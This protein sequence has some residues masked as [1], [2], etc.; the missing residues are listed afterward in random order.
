VFDATAAVNLTTT[1][2]TE[3]SNSATA[4]ATSATNASNS[5]TAAQASAVESAAQASKLF[6]TS[7]TS[8]ILGLGAKTFVT[9]ASKY[10]NIGKFIMVR[11]NADPVDSWMWGQVASYSGTTLIVNV[12]TFKGSAAFADWIIDVS[13]IKGADGSGGGSGTSSVTTSDTAPATPHDGD[14]W[15]KTDTGVMYVYYDDG[16]SQQWVQAVAVP[17]MGGVVA[18]DADQNFTELQKAQG[19]ENIYAAPLDALAYNGMQVNGSIEVSQEVG[20]GNV[21]AINNYKYTVDSG[22]VGSNGVQTLNATRYANSAPGS[23]RKTLLVYA[24]PTNSSPAASDYAFLV[25]RLEGYRISRLNWGTASAKSITIAFWI[26]A[27]RAGNYS[28][29]VQNG[30]NTRSYP[31]PITVSVPGTWEYKV[32]TIPGDTTG[33]WVVDN[34]MGMQIFITLMA[35]SNNTA[36]ANAWVAGSK[37]GVNGTINGVMPSD[38]IYISDFIVL[39]GI[40]APTAAQLPLIMRPYDQELVMCQRYYE[41]NTDYVSCLRW[42]GNT[43]SSGIYYSTVF[44][45][46]RKR[47]TPT[48]TIVSNEGVLFPNTS[49]T[50]VANPEGFYEP[51][52]ANGAGVGRFGSDWVADARL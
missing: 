26:N 6:G 7:T 5:A 17:T 42:S 15:W 29:A 39:P 4:A 23:Q 27:V 10:F 2:A 9:Q 24:N 18:V 44:F 43:T 48:M 32:I 40:E 35:G 20:D 8:V 38:G 30:N 49:G 13:G 33:T 14:L 45:K 25:N 22:V 3:A 1:K 28:G 46:T 31:F 52:T 47:A 21:G 41:K 12:Q 19:R 50:P 11:A 16:D 36:P 34:T 37:I 51:R